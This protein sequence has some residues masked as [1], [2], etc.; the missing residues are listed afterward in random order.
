MRFASW[1]STASRLL[2]ELKKSVYWIIPWS[3]KSCWALSWFS[4]RANFCI[5]ILMW[6][7][8]MASPR[9]IWEVSLRV[10][11]RSCLSSSLIRRCF[12]FEV[13]RWPSVRKPSKIFH[14]TSRPAK[15]LARLTPLSLVV[16]STLSS[17]TPVRKFNLGNCSEWMRMKLFFS[18]SSSCSN[19]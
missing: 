5:W 3:N 14:R 18:I 7:R 4:L 9:K 17:K 11:W 2:L 10:F 19:A 13:I 15:T 12:A 16:L 8:S 6:S 1:Y